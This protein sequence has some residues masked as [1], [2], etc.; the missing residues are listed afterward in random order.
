MQIALK[1][2]LISHFSSMLP[3]QGMLSWHCWQGPNDARICACSGTCNSAVL[4]RRAFCA[5]NLLPVR[6]SSSSKELHHHFLTVYFLQSSFFS[7]AP[8]QWLVEPRD[9]QVV[10][11]QSARVDC[12]AS[13]S[14]K[15]FTTWKRATGKSFKLGHFQ[16]C[17]SIILFVVCKLELQIL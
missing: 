17:F 8:P 3:P 13:G 7:A 6:S 12:L 2:N 9:T 1:I 11:H 15:P 16:T 14:P 4:C 5:T 10:L